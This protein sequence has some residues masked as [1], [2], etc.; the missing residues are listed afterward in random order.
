MGS[1]GVHITFVRSI[2]MDSWT[3]EQLKIMIAGGNS[4]CASYLSNKGIDKN[5]SIKSKYESDVAQLYKEVL[6]ARVAGKPEPTQ[7]IK[8]KNKL[9]G[10]L[11]N[12]NTASSAA[13][14]GGNATEDV[15]GMERLT[16]E[17]DEKYIARQ[18]RLRDEARVRMAAK[19]GGSS[20]K[21]SGAG[22]SSS[23]SGVGSDPS[24]NPSGGYNMNDV[25]GSITA[26]LGS[27]WN[28]IGSVTSKAS[29]AL[30]DK[31]TQQSVRNLTS[32]VKSTSF[33]LWSDLSA[34]AQEVVK[35]LGEP[36]EGDGL[37]ELQR[38]AKASR[39]EQNKYDGFG[40]EGNSI[41]QSNNDHKQNTLE[42]PKQEDPEGMIPLTGESNDDYL[43][44][45]T[46][47]RD[48]AKLRMETKFGKNRTL[49]VASSS[50]TDMIPP[51]PKVTKKEFSANSDDFF[52]S[53]GS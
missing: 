11:G 37:F 33:S 48:E 3:P 26:G 6:K 46:R 17:S 35:S 18:T 28:T 45:Q 38:H 36:D 29:S 24:Y 51:K 50:N 42:P 14:T 39:S 13:Q 44:R 5:A 30:T 47:I 41:D 23:M 20:S 21:M 8:K 22:G 15:N 4:K 34:S 43:K 9:K 2:A 27:A 25:S 52:S 31:Q 49:P 16:G 7:L 12:N 19:F 53:F 10:S 40:S 32:S 1:L